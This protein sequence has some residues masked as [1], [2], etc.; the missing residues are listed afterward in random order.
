MSLITERL[1]LCVI[2]PG[3]WQALKRIV[4]DFDASPYAPYDHAFP[5]EDAGLREAAQFF[6]ASGLF[7]MATLRESGEIIGYVSLWPEE[8]AFSLGYC[9][10]SDFHGRG[11]AFEACSA[12]MEALHQMGVRKFVCGTALDNTPSMRLIQRLGFEMTSS[13]LLSFRKD[14]EGRGITFR[15]GWFI[16]EYPDL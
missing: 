14:A 7:Y 15:G 12:L 3:D 4:R 16:K 5:T 9:F 6:S 1:L 8:D 2:E 13:E 10:H 11:L